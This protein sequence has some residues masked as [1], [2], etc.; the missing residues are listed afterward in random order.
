MSEE[1]ITEKMNLQ[2]LFRQNIENLRGWGISEHAIEEITKASR[3]RIDLGAEVYCSDSGAECIVPHTC[4][5]KACASCGYLRTAVWTGEACSQIPEIPFASIIF[6]MRG[7]LWELFRRNRSLLWALPEIGAKVVQEWARVEYGADVAII[8]AQHTFG[9]RLNFNCHLHLM[10]SRT[11]ISQT[12]QALV[13]NIIFPTQELTRRW[14]LTVLALLRSA[15]TEGWL[16]SDLAEDDLLRTLTEEAA[17]RWVSL[18]R[19]LEDGKQY[20]RYMGR[21]LRRPPITN[22]RLLPSPD[23]Y[24]FFKFWRK[25]P[26]NSARLSEDVETRFG[27]FKRPETAKHPIKEFFQLLAD[28]IPDRYSHNVRYFGLLGPRSSTRYRIFLHLLGKTFRPRRVGGQHWLFWRMKR[29]GI[30]PLLDPEGK[31]MEWDRSV[32]PSNTTVPT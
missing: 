4:K 30:N 16:D 14:Q 26:R 25:L 23:G 2:T 20:L 6:T 22:N 7:Y 10:V 3:C 32:G 15:A 9:A 31:R 27:M 1:S 11:G 21:Y 28:Q 5:S 24:V 29:F 13:R 18:A 17:T 19:N 8:V 12:K